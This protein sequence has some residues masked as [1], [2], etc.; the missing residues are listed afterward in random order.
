MERGREIEASHDGS[1]GSKGRGFVPRWWV[2]GEE[3]RARSWRWRGEGSYCVS[4]WNTCGR[5]GDDLG[6]RREAT[7]DEAMYEGWNV[8]GLS[9]GCSL[10][11]LE[12]GMA[13]V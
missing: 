10:G 1:D 13:L 9:L 3:K 4:G 6:A 2:V 11:R 12:A 8:G 7:L 5:L